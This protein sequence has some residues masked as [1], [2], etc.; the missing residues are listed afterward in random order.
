[1]G[2]EL[3]KMKFDISD[4]I[5]VKFENIQNKMR[6]ETRILKET[7]ATLSKRLEKTG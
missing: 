4:S 5:D 2:R 1:L 7:F 6:E 3:E